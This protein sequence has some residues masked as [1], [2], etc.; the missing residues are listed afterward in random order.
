VSSNRP[1]LPGKLEL[2]H[3][4]GTT[5]RIEPRSFLIQV[6]LLQPSFVSFSFS[7]YCL[8]I[9]LLL[10]V[11]RSA[12]RIPVGASFSLPVQTGRGDH[13]ASYTGGTGSFSPGTK[14][15]GLGVDH[16][17]PHLAPR[18]KK[19]YIYTYTPA[20]GLYGL[21]R[22]QEGH[23]DSTMATAQSPSNRIT[24]S[25]VTIATRLAPSPPA[26]LLLDAGWRASAQTLSVDSPGGRS[27]EY[28]R[29]GSSHSRTFSAGSVR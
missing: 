11:G 4:S 8:F 7:L 23:N 28:G 15:P 5:S 16:S 13:P 14:R 25:R 24:L 17:R 20:R 1:R 10:R 9:Y 18:L 26:T 3:T 29:S 12:D 2:L 27:A 6:K 19:E 21:S 22:V